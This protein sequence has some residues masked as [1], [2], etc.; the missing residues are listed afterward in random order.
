MT[1]K[2]DV[3]PERSFRRVEKTLRIAQL[4]HQK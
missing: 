2:F 3:L 1:T 4:Q